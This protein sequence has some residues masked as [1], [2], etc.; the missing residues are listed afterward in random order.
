MFF[1][2]HQVAG[3]KR[4]DLKSVAMRDGV[5]RASF[6]AITAEDAAVVVNVVNLG[7]TLGPADAVFGGVL[8]GF[9][10]NAVRWAGRG[11][12]KTRHALLQAVFIAL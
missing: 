1:A 5:R 2:V 11:A 9:D 7:V 3:I 8:R 10:I 4:G 12:E 6:H